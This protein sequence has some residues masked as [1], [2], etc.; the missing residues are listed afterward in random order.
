[1]SNCPL[2]N[3]EPAPNPGAGKR[4]AGLL[5]RAGR[6]IQWLVPVTLLAL[7][8]KCPVCVAAYVALFTGVGI[9]IAAA[10]W[11]R[12]LMIVLCFASLA[13]LVFRKALGIRKGAGDRPHPVAGVKAE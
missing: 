3:L 4:P 13:Y 5:R 7:M 11:V 1:M 10:R 2:C 6:V 12:M 8:P 9:S